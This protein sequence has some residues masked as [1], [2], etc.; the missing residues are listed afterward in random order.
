MID[1]EVVTASDRGEHRGDG[2]LGHVLD[3]L[4]TGAD[5]VMVMFGVAGD[6]CGDMTLPLEAARHPILDLLFEGRSDA[7]IDAIKASAATAS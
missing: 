5:Q 2:V 3:T 7:V 6:V 4:T 1:L